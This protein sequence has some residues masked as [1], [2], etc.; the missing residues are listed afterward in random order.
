MTHTGSFFSWKVLAIVCALMAPFL[1]YF[2]TATSIVAIWN[3]S[4]TFAHGYIILPISLWLIWRRRNVL[5]QMTP[6][7]CWLALL[8]LLGCGFG[9]LLAELADVQVARQYMFV[10]MIPLI[11][12]V[13]LGWRIAWSMAFPLFFLV[14]AVPFGDVFLAPLINFTADFTVAAVQF[15]G[16]P[17][18]REGTT[19]TLPSGNWSVV[20]ACSGLRYLISSFTLGCL[21]AY[22]TYKSPKRRLIFIL[23]AIITPIIANGLRAFMI[24]MIG[25]FSGMTLAV[26]FD[27]LIYGWVFFG[28]VMFLMFWVGSFW[29]ESFDDANPVQLTKVQSSAPFSSIVTACISAILCIAIWPVYAAFI[30]RNDVNTSAVKLEQFKSDWQEAADFVSWKPGFSPAYA[31]MDKSYQNNSSLIG[32]H[33]GYYRNQDRSSTLINSINQLVKHNVNEWQETSTALRSENVGTQTIPVKET[34]IRGLGASLLV[35]QWYWIDGKFMA[36][37]YQ[38]KFW[39]AKQKLLMHGDDGAV[40]IFYAPYEENPEKARASLRQFLSTNLAGIESSLSQSKN[41]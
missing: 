32:M 20:E 14:L 36:N 21:Y 3:S 38:G 6:Q 18:L 27:H 26:G 16:I 30:N 11:V 15:T 9:W 17:I 2:S 24:V 13:V 39:L 23:F 7:P 19:F 31:E 1:I 41:P 34:K 25:H 5:M 12:V 8:A 35:W 29:R 22:L 40:L 28:L 4:E 33:L 10:A 37:A